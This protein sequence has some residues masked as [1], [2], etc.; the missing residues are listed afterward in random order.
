MDFSHLP[1]VELHVHLD[2][3][4]SFEAVNKLRPQITLEEYNQKFIGPV[5]C[6]DLADFLTRA[7][8][9]IEIMQTEDEL[10]C[11]VFDLFEQFKKDNVIYAE[12]RYAPLLHTEKGLT[13]KDVVKIVNQATEEAISKFNIEVGIILCTLRHFSEAQSMETIK[14]VEEFK[15]T[16][17]V[18]FDIAADEAGYPID[19]HLT[20]FEYA[21]KKD[22]KCTAH[23]GE[24]KGAQSVHETIDNF[25]P[26]R[27]GHGV[28]S[29]EDQDLITRLINENIHLEVC[30]TSNIQVNV[31]D[32]YSDHPIDQIYKHGVSISINTDARTISDID[33]N[34]EYT[35]L[36]QYF[37]WKI[38]HFKKC[39]LE[40][41]NH[42]FANEELKRT[43]KN[44]LI[45]AYTTK[46]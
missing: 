31:F 37:D 16:K 36:V 24:A 22:I 42:A 39:N 44:K 30:P 7:L 29:I 27:I 20:A 8:S 40:A 4:M 15:G 5:K 46:S 6:H 28:R 10:R 11:I 25:S 18:G 17:V 3:C 26:R 2:C 21:N 41:I 45:D 14:L 32:E 19:A 12:F 33:L 38:E 13:P 35:R 9:G 23:A 34:R 43:I 1:K